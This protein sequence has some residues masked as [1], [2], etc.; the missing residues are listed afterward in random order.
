M[1]VTS[2]V[3]VMSASRVFIPDRLHRCDVVVGV[4]DGKQL[5]D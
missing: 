1:Y 2:L 3:P 4:W 5:L